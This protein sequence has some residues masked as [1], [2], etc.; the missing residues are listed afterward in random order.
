VRLG[1]EAGVSFTAPGDSVHS[2]LCCCHVQDLIRQLGTAASGDARFKAYV[3]LLLGLV[4]STVQV[5]QYV[6]S[7]GRHAPGAWASLG[8]PGVLLRSWPHS[9]HHSSNQEILIDLWLRHMFSGIAYV[10]DA[11]DLAVSSHHTR[12]VCWCCDAASAGKHS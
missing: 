3:S 5:R 4:N 7:A 9:Q 6:C 11:D 8:S 2:C 1:S 12:A 10:C